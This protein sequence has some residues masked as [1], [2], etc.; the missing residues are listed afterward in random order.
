MR[1]LFSC[2]HAIIHTIFLF[3]GAVVVVLIAAGLFAYTM[4]NDSSHLI[5]ENGPLWRRLPIDS[6]ALSLYH[7]LN[8]QAETINTPISND[9]S[10]ISFTIEPGETA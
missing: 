10:L 4:I 6:E 1:R 3:L 5:I 8:T 2:L 9:P 7:E